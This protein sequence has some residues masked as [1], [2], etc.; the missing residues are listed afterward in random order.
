MHEG[1]ISA[2]FDTHTSHSHGFI[3][4]PLPPFVLSKKRSLPVFASKNHSGTKRSWARSSPP[5]GRKTISWTEYLLSTA[6]IIWSTSIEMHP[7]LSS[8]TA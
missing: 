1:S 8:S 7:R 3:S 2:P 5:C 6:V 4:T